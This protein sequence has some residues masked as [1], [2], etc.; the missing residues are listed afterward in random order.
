M[1]VVWISCEQFSVILPLII[2]FEYLTVYISSNLNKYNS[3][4]KTLRVSRLQAMKGL[5]L[6]ST[7]IMTLP[8][9]FEAIVGGTKAKR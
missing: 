3:F 1:I 5:P 4:G 9:Y 7:T 8:L 6:A 2:A